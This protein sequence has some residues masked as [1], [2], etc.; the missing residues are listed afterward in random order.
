MPTDN[1]RRNLK[2]NP[3]C[4]QTGKQLPSLFTFTYSSENQFNILFFVFGTNTTYLSN[5]VNRYFGCNL[6][7]LL[8]AYRIGHARELLSEDSCSVREL[9]ARCGFASKSVFYAAFARVVGMSPLQYLS[10]SRKPLKIQ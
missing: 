5:T 4:I 1:S 9:Y 2:D 8:N 7:Q 10:Q 3:E 6:K